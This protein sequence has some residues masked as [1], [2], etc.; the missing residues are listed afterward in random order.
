MTNRALPPQ[1]QENLVARFASRLEETIGFLI[2]DAV[3]SY[4][5]VLAPNLARSGIKLGHYMFLRIL[6]EHEGL[7]FRELS[8]AAHMRGPTV[9]EAVRDMERR[10]LVRRKG[11]ANDARKVHLFLTGKGRRAHDALVRVSG[12]INRIGVA[13]LTR[14]DQ[15]KLKTLLRHLRRNM[16]EHEAT[17]AGDFA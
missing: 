14:N 7:T 6:H 1:E 16:N 11:N 9:V 12:A 2:W 13:G 10:G 8:D 17:Q 15:E 3:R 5:R 4:Q